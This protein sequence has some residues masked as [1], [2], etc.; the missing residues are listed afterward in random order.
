M[1]ELSKTLTHQDSFPQCCKSS[2]IAVR[3]QGNKKKL[4]SYFSEKIAGGPHSDRDSSD[5][6]VFFATDFKIEL[7]AVIRQ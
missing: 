5:S 7:D 1:P 6:T 3:L 2:K 4:Y